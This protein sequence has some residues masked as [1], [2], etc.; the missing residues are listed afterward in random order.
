VGVG[1]AV[2]GGFSTTWA[3]TTQVAAVIRGLFAQDVAV[4]NLG[5][6]IEIARTSVRAAKGGMES[7][8]SL[9]AFLSL[10]IAIMNLIPIPVLDGGQMLMTIA[11]GV[12]G[13]ELSSRTREWLARAGVLTVL[14]LIVMVTFNDLRRLVVG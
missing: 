6:P 12:K 13:S 10:N 2:V 7:L 3:M 5:G 14:L 9:I 1:E 4:S 8:W 11:E